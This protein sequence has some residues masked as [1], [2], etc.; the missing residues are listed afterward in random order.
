MISVGGGFG[1]IV[2]AIYFLF[3]T[4]SG[5]LRII[6]GLYVVF[7]FVVSIIAACLSDEPL[8]RLGIPGLVAL[9]MVVA[10]NI[11]NI[12]KGWP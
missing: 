10:Y 3:F 8:L 12:W 6:G 2:L 11:R 9:L 5:W 4:E 1:L 7:F